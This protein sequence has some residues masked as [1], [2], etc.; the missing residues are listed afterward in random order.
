[1]R[2]RIL[3]LLL[4]VFL[5]ALPAWSAGS[6]A[7][8][9]WSSLPL[10]GGDVWSLAITPQDPDVVF[11]GTS[12]G[13]VYLSRDGGRTW[14]DAG[15]TLPFPGWVVSSLRFDPNKPSRLWASLRG[16]WGG[17]H[18]AS[19][20]DQGRTWASRSQEGLPNEPVYTLALVPGHEG[21]IYAGTASGVYGTEDGGKTWR[22][23][24]ADLPEVQKVTSLMVDPDQ[25]DS[26]IAG[27]W[28]QAYRSD[29]A[30]KSW[31]G[32]FEGMVLD[33]EVFSLTPVPGKPGEIWASTCGWV[34]VTRDRGGKWERFKEGFEE[35]RTPSFA[36]LPGGRLLAGTVAGL[37][38][39][40]DGGKTWRRVGDPGISI[41]AIAYHPA[42]PQRIVFATEGA[43][44]W[45]SDDGGST[46]R[47]GS[48]GM[49]NT[50]VGAFAE[51][52]KELLVGVNHAGPFSGVYSSHDGGRSFDDFAF[53]PT[54][55]DLA[56][57]KGRVFAATEKGLF[58]R[59]GRGWHWVRDLGLGTVEQF[60]T[61]GPRLLARTPDAIYELDGK[62]FTRRPFKHGT[63]RSAAFYGDALWVTDSQGLYRLT[64]D[65][66]HTIPVPFPGGRLQSLEGQLLLWGP[67][68]TF[69]KTAADAEWIELS[70]ESS[71]LLA[72]GDERFP[73]LMVSGDT[74]RLFDRETRKFE[75]I[76]VPVPARDLAAARVVDGRLLLG[77]TGYGVLARDLPGPAPA[78][79]TAR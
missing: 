37:H 45:T 79:Q 59:R 53:L 27:T 57:Y 10:W 43:G 61:D 22:H 44:V 35:R 50:R 9:A 58:E 4:G 48:G 68:G 23:L 55:L 76:E 31:A 69:T 1:M 60:V 16:I 18:V 65:A 3:I 66:N 14:I 62:L 39:S 7:G 12:A 38:V 63:P 74:V 40:D 8:P 15:P 24:T 21:R 19:S 41:Q 36:A 13:Q 49:I 28:R 52:G 54:V 42:K 67:G 71:R 70:R 64:A 29:D 25:P 56:V 2:D 17:G 34:Y 11:A 72:T 77:T 75:P 47:P 73:A 5:C 26:V 30:G 51:A 33:S 32:V 6:S 20:D 46:L 78:A